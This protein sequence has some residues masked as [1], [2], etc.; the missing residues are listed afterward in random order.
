MK[1][2]LIHLTLLFILV[3]FTSYSSAETWSTTFKVLNMKAGDVACYVDLT[4]NNGDKQQVMANFDICEKRYFIGKNVTGYFEQANV[5]AASCNGNMDCGRSDTVVLLTAMEI[6]Q[7]PR[8]NHRQPVPVPSHCF[9]NERVIFSCNTNSNK[10]ISICA[11]QSSNPNQGYMQY[12]FGSVGFFPEF[13]FPSNHDYATKFFYSGELNYSGG[14]GAY[15]KFIN[16]SHNYVVY[17]GIGR[18]WEKQGLVV[19]EG[20]NEIS[21]YVCKD[22]WVSEM[23]PDLFS[24]IGLKVDPY[25]FEIPYD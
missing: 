18:G 11:A 12:R 14:G 22:S 19:N 7:P 8:Q 1:N 3:L 10:V 21:R 2:T 17:T 6:L 20:I 9:D 15:L 4:D 24:Q 13:V 25:G 16:G 5:L 23:G